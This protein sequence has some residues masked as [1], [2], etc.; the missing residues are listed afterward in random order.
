MTTDQKL[1]W[2]GLGFLAVLACF[3]GVLLGAVLIRRNSA[4]PSPPVTPDRPASPVIIIVPEPSD[5]PT[6]LT[7]ATPTPWP[8]IPPTAVPTLPPVTPSPSTPLANDFE[9]LVQ[10][11]EA[12]TPI[13][14]E[15]LAAAERDGDILEASEQNPAALCGAGR[16][17]HPT[18][19]ADAA[20]MDN[21]GNQLEAITPPAEAAAAVHKPLLE[22]LRLWRDALHN[23]NLS[24][25]TDDPTGQGLLRLGAALQLGGSLLN[26]Q[27]ATT[28]FWRL[29]ITQGLEEIVGTPSP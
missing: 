12:I 27:T 6:P 9:G 28:N 4:S 26:F 21:L 22:S 13:L 11:A 17:P 10:Y 16:V 7:V 2:G 29:I 24:C 18:L 1:L 15:G 3:F 20:L 5:T 14:E 23:I 25:Q 8:T 19:V